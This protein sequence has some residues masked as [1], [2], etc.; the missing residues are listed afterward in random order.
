MDEIQF[1]GSERRR[2]SLRTVVWAAVLLAAIG[3]LV[4]WQ[5]QGDSPKPVSAGSP[6]PT[7]PT[8]AAARV[9][10][11]DP[12]APASKPAVALSGQLATSG[13]WAGELTA[14]TRSLVVR[15]PMRNTG[16]API[17]L[18]G[19]SVDHPST[20]TID[21]IGVSEHP[22]STLDDIARAGVPSSYTLPAGASA[23]LVVAATF[24]CPSAKQVADPKL[25]LT[26]DG[27]RVEIALLATTGD[28][29][30]DMVG[31]WCKANSGSG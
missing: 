27:R 9:V 29:I 10:V 30:E 7:S 15:V 1:G 20:V 24:R 22:L 14:K 13:A 26:Q 23:Y 25:R 18:S 16:D 5:R 31:D 12:A 3:G 28:W 2:P 6:S 21:V 11:A 4:I 17:R 19:Y 8:T